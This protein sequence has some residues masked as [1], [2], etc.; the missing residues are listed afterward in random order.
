MQKNTLSLLIV[1]LIA[2]LFVQGCGADASKSTPI[3]VTV[4]ASSVLVVTQI[5]NG[6]IEPP[7]ITPTP[8][9]SDPE[10]VFVTLSTAYQPP[11]PVHLSLGQKLYVVSP[12]G[13][14]ENGWNL[15]FDYSF[16]QLDSKNAPKGFSQGWW[17]WI[18]LKAGESTI[19]I[20]DAP[21]PCFYSNY[22]CTLPQFWARLN[23]VVS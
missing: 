21:L 6:T 16:F 10:G 12:A 13:F 23:V 18:P 3:I 20:L 9:V 22:P 2:M 19:E 14:G 5:V 15:T 11:D 4:K 7:P 8:P 1:F 17:I